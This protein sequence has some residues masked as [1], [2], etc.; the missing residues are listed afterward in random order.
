MFH[1]WDIFMIMFF[2]SSEE[3]FTIVECQF[4]FR[5]ASSGQIKNTLPQRAHQ[6][7]S[8][9]KILIVKVT[10][11]CHSSYTVVFRSESQVTYS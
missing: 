3:S 7:I 10:L 2:Q 6:S 5:F 9:K 8:A 11:V 1:I 4:S